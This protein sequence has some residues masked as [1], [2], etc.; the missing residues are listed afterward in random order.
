M[1]NRSV[2]LAL[3]AVAIAPACDG[4]SALR[5]FPLPAAS[6]PVGITVGSDGRLWFAEYF[7]DRIAALTVSGELQ[8][9]WVP[10]RRPYRVTTGADGNVWFVEG[11]TGTVGHVTP[12]GAIGHV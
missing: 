2:I 12:G 5:E 8:E 9:F 7:R 10:L 4:A 6:A 11:G 3:L 1:T